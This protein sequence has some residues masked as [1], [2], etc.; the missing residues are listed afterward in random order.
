VVAVI[1]D[2]C[3]WVPEDVGQQ[4]GH[5]EDVVALATLQ[6]GPRPAAV[7]GWPGTAPT[8]AHR[9]G[10]AR[11]DSEDLL[12]ADVVVPVVGEVVVVDEPLGPPQPESAQGDLAVLV[13]AFVLVP[14]NLEAMEVIVLPGEGDLQDGVQLGQG[15]IGANQET[16]PD[17]R[18]DP[19]QHH[20]QLVDGQG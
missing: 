2:A 17:E 10:T 9:V 3:L 16:A 14:V 15:G 20:A 19:S 1:T 11:L 6:V 13:E 12:D 4:A 18:A 7:L 8:G 5:G